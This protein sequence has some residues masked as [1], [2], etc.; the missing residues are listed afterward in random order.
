M[1][2]ESQIDEM[3]AALRGDRERAEQSR[4]RSSENVL[5]LI[6]PQA[7]EVDAEPQPEPRRGFLSRLLGR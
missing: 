5:G 7:A 3:R 1:K 2:D 4:Q 6:E